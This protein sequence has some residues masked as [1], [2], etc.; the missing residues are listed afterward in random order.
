MPDQS[1]TKV[2]LFSSFL[3]THHVLVG[4][5]QPDLLILTHFLNRRPHTRQFVPRIDRRLT[6]WRDDDVIKFRCCA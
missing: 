2:K 1:F 4:Q 5:R 6:E 3:E